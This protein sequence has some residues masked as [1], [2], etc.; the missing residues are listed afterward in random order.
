MKTVI[1][2]PAANLV[3]NVTVGEPAAPAPAG[4]EYIV[5]ENDVWVGPGCKR[6]EDGTYYMPTE[7]EE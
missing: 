3:I 1:Y 4:L 6:A 2:D 5:V 7:E